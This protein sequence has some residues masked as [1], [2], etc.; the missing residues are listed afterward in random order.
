MIAMIRKT[1]M[2]V[3]VIFSTGILYAQE[4]NLATEYR[5]TIIMKNGT[6][7]EGII[8]EQTPKGDVWIKAAS[9][10]LTFDRDS[11]SINST[12]GTTSIRFKNQMFNDVEILEDGDIITFRCNH[13]TL[14]QTKLSEVDRV[15]KPVVPNVL[16]VIIADKSYE[17]SIVETAFGRYNKIL[18]GN[19]K[20]VIKNKKVKSQSRKTEAEG[21]ENLDV[22]LFPYL[23]VYEMKDKSVVSGILVSQNMSDGALIFKT[24]SGALLPLNFSNIAKVRKVVNNN[25]KE[26]VYPLDTASMA[27]LSI[28]DIEA[29]PIEVIYEKADIVCV[30]VATGE[31]MILIPGK[32][33]TLCQKEKVKEYVLVPF[34]PLEGLKN[35]YIRLGKAE[36]LSSVKPTLVEKQDGLTFTD[37]K[38]LKAGY[39]ILF[40]KEEGKIIPLWVRAA[41]N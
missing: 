8:S 21:R 34:N 22:T 9:S 13:E 36:T 15:L 10:T 12:D 24:E 11:I 32:D 18:S 19:K 16:D 23:D 40:N 38:D 31:D 25:Y 27:S 28:N 17:G 39:Y 30:P 2:A 41:E 35:G 20:Y 5:D 14:V 26:V 4:T 33:V 37:Y 1:L 6:V 3:A 29:K 7:Y